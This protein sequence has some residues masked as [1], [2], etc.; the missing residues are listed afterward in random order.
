MAQA[1]GDL[2]RAGRRLAD[3]VG[4]GAGVASLA[5][6]TQLIGQ[7]AEARRQPLDLAVGLAPQLVA[8][9]VR[10]PASLA[11]GRPAHVAGL[12]GGGGRDVPGLLGRRLGYLLRP[13][14]PNG[15]RLLGPLG[16]RGLARARGTAVDGTWGA[17]VARPRVVPGRGRRGQ[18]VLV[19]HVLAPCVA[20][21]P[22]NAA[23]PTQAVRKQTERP[24]ADGID[25]MT[26]AWR[27]D[28]SASPP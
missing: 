9:V 5:H 2:L 7:L 17:G 24:S 14:A 13:V 16:A 6:R 11:L 18:P 10:Q 21:P 25:A 19:T 15:R 8:G 12:A 1:V 22:V 3:K 4:D 20:S 27:R 26:H 28:Q 23:G